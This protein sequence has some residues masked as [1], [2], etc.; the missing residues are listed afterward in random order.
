MPESRP[1]KA[2]WPVVR[3]PEH[4]EQ[5]GGEERGVDE[6]EDE[7]QRVH[8]V[9][10]VGDEVGG[11]D[12]ERDA[13]DG[14]HAAHPEIVGVGGALVDVGL[15]DV[16]GPDGVEGGDVAGHA[17]HEAGEQR[18]EAEAEDSGWEEVEEH[19]GD[20]EVVVIDGGAVGVEDGFAADGVGFDGD[21]AVGVGFVEGKRGSVG[22]GGGVCGVASWSGGCRGRHHVGGDADGDEA[23]QDD[24]EREEHFRDG[25]DEGDAA[26][27]DLG[28]GGHGALDDEEVGAPVAEGE[29]EAEAHGEADPLRR[30]GCWWWRG[31]CPAR[32][33]S[34]WREGFA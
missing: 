9:V 26:G 14:G 5:E 21:D 24:E 25:G 20:G 29:N 32:S 27:G 23:G 18:G 17:G 30:R 1:V 34:C 28:V 10:E 6:G 8:D 19:D 12:G 4:A 13:A 11:T 2:P 31:P 22:C 15:I 33:G 7:L 3:L 16:V